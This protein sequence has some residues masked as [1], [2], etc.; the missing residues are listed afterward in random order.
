M[1]VGIWLVLPCLISSISIYYVPESEIQVK[2]YDHLNI[3][4]ASIVQFR[5]S[6]YIIGLNQTFESKVMA[7]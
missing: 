3:W 7:I 5:V 4:R 1:A 6:Q 2:G